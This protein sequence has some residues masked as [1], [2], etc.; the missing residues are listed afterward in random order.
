MSTRWNAYNG[1]LRL[2]T[3]IISRPPK[4]SLYVRSRTLASYVTQALLSVTLLLFF[5]NVF[6]VSTFCSLLLATVCLKIPSRDH[7]LRDTARSIVLPP[8]PCSWYLI[9]SISGFNIQREDSYA[10]LFV[11]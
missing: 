7:R 4:Y 10:H 6:V 2:H 11:I 5:I 3:L 1:S 8:S 9:Q